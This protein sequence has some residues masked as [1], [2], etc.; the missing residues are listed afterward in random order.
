LH[1]IASIVDA[2]FPEI[3]TFTED[4]PHIEAA[5][6]VSSQAL[7]EGMTQIKQGLAKVSEAIE[8]VS[9]LSLLT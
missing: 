6:K 3:A 9:C 1:H 2:S 4:M 5:A 8:Q 7:R